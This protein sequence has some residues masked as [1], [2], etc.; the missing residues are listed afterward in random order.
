MN[1]PANRYVV[2][3][4][5]PTA[6]DAFFAWNFFDG[7]LQQKEGYSAYVFEDVAA[8][9]L[10]KDPALKKE[11]EEKKKSDPDFAKDGAAQLD[12]VYHHSPYFEP[13]YLR[14]PVYRLE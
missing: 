6:P 7:I 8:K 1:Q 12:F 11:L 14:Y 4:L 9:L 5:E 13:E 2:E 10:K 3:T